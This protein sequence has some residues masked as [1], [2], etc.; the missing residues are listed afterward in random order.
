MNE[1]N[2]K[3]QDYTHNQTT[4]LAQVEGGFVCVHENEPLV[5]AVL[6]NTLEEAQSDNVPHLCFELPDRQQTIQL[7]NMLSSTRLSRIGGE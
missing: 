7:A 6:A 4:K 2:S 5:F 3:F 1:L